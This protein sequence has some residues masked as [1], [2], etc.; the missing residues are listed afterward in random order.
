MLTERGLDPGNAWAM[1]RRR[2]RQAG[3]AAP[4]CNHS[5]RA[6]ALTAYM[7]NGGTLEGAQELA[8][9]ADARTTRL[10]IRQ[11]RKITQSAIER[12]RF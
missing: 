7:D 11:E 8:N 10:Y 5:F 2:L 6:M 9:H 3:I 4:L 1:V 12:I